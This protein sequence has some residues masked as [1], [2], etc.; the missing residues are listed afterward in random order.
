ME[1]Q[2]KRA[3]ERLKAL[4]INSM[5]NSRKLSEMHDALLGNKVWQRQGMVERL[6]DIEEKVDALTEIKNRSVWLILT[7]GG[8]AGAIGGFFKTILS[9]LKGV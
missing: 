2:I 8:I 9:W 3:E 1:E 4:E 5:E 6:K 7:L